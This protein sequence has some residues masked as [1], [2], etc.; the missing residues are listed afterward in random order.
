MIPIHKYWIYIVTNPGRTV[1]YIGVTSDLPKRLNQHFSNKGND[2]SFA[3][4]YHCYN[5]IHYEE[6]KYIDK[7]IAREKQLKKWSRKKK[8]YLIGI[9]NPKWLFYN[10][11]F[12]ILQ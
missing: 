12:P 7:A 3:G 5:L 2:D 9:E 8:E 6:F 1:L 11:R 4:K 10:S